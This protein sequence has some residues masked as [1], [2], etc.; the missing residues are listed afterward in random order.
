VDRNLK[1]ISPKKEQFEPTPSVPIAQ[2]K[3]MAGTG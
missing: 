3:R 1:A 2:H